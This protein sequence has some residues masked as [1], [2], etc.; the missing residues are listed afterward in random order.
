MFLV[1]CIDASYINRHVYTT[2]LALRD[3]TTYTWLNILCGNIIIVPMAVHKNGP[4]AVLYITMDQW[5]CCPLNWTNICT[6]A[7]LY[8]EIDINE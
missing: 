1:Y 7:V 5:L 3:V 4:M 6:V 2:H 8:T